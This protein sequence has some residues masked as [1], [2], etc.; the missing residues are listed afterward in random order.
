MRRGGVG[1]WGAVISSRLSADGQRQRGVVKFLRGGDPNFAIDLRCRRTRRQ[2]G[3][4][5]S[6][7]QAGVGRS[8]RQAGVGRSRRQAGVGRSRRQAGLGTSRLRRGVGGSGQSRIRRFRCQTGVG[9]S[10]QGAVQGRVGRSRRQ[11]GL[12]RSR[13]R[14]DLRCGLGRSLCALRFGWRKRRRLGRTDEGGWHGRRS[15]AFG[16]RGGW[17]SGD[18]RGLPNCV[19]RP[20]RRCPQFIDKDGSAEL[21]RLRL[22]LASIID[23]E[24]R[25]G[26]NL[27]DDKRRSAWW[28]APRP[29]G[30]ASLFI[31]NSRRRRRPGSRRVIWAT[32]AGAASRHPRRR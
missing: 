4:G 32:V 6:R 1:H 29:G 13:W 26:T 21:L 25:R 12:G 10:W 30:L 18:R 2:A 11:A 15:T 5:R 22:R 31:S 9:R 16:H 28:R 27:F 19:G 7:R 20:R 17:P 23:R 24:Q 3:V 8:R 14:A